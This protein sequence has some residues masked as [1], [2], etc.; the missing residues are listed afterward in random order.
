M[1]LLL[2][3]VTL[4]F[5][6]TLASVFAMRRSSAALLH[7]ICACS[8]AGALV[9][10]LMRITPQGAVVIRVDAL[11]PASA[12]PI[13]HAAP[14]IVPTIL[15]VLPSLWIAG[16]TVLLGRLAIG[17]AQLKGLIRNARSIGDTGVVFADVSVPVVAGL[18]RP[19]ILLP[20]SA[21]AWAPSRMDAVL[22]H[23]RAHLRRKDLWTLLLSHVACAAYWFHPL[24]WTVAARLRREQEFACDDAVILS[25]FKAASY[26]EPLIAAAQNLTSTQLIGC[27]MITQRTFRSRIARLLAGGMPRISS[28]STP[29]SVAIVFAC[30]VAT[31]GLLSGT[32]Q[33]PDQNGVYDAN[34][35]TPPPRVI[36]RVDPDFSEEARAGGLEG[37]VVFHA[38]IGTDGRAHNINVFR[39]LGTIPDEKALQALAQWRFEPGRKAG[40]AVEVRATVV[41][42]V[43]PKGNGDWCAPFASGLTFCSDA[44][45]KPK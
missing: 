35:L 4:L 20:R 22:R 7:L 11:S 13:A 45:P 17:Y 28:P 1:I 14:V 31:L 5:A 25:G 37:A 23:E 36:A 24:V 30:G 42:H 34:G 26:A 15:R 27:P 21:A 32:P 40:E 39:S 2:S 41:M 43:G 33:S 16:V 19:V 18:L 10:L 38:V 44:N 9:L 8:L 6:I 12:G 29:R 3:K